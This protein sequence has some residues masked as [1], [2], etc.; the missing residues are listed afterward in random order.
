MFLGLRLVLMV[1]MLAGLLGERIVV[2]GGLRVAR[3]V[4]LRLGRA[5]P[6]GSRRG[7]RRCRRRVWRRR[8]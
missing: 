6:V 7:R 2:M 4:L 3:R 1:L 8:V 5:S